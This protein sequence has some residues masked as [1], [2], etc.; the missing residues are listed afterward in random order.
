MDP[1]ENTSHE[2]RGA[3]K[4]EG[5]KLSVL[6]SQVL[7][8][9]PDIDNSFTFAEE[10]L[11]SVLEEGLEGPDENGDNLS[12]ITFGLERDLQSALRQNTKQLEDGLE[13]IDGGSEI[14]TVTG[15]IDITAKDKD[16]NLIAV[17]LK[18]GKA[19]SDVISQV[20]AHMS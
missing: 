15:R 7:I 13:I 9:K 11:D 18:A 12:E 10:Y 6:E 17:E 20:L 19:R 4:R 3:L 16:G 1:N 14:V 8:I 2:L 5:W